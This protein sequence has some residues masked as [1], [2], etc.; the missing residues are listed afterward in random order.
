[1]LLRRLA[2][3]GQ[4]LAPA[5]PLLW[6]VF[7]FWTVLYLCLLASGINEYV[8]RENVTVAGLRQ[9]LALILRFTDAIWIL[10]AACVVH[11]SMARTQGN[12]RARRSALVIVLAAAAAAWASATISLPFGP[13]RYTTA[14]G[15]KIANI[16]PFAVPLLWLV[17]V[18]G[19][20][21]FSARLL[22]G[23]GNAAVALGA[24]CL[25]ALTDLNLEFVAWKLRTW[26][27][28]YPAGHPLAGDPPAW[29]PLQNYLTWFAL[30]TLLSLASP[31]FREG[32][33][34]P[35]RPIIALAI[36]NFLLLTT[37]LLP[38]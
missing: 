4:Y 17:V 12:V 25:T 31:P 9:A 6:G 15:P 35:L 7:L 3:L 24:G 10:L 16:L 22:A 19:A 36:L 8:I 33:K 5:E 2:R 13:L 34:P 14:L 27:I 23:K 30:G 38:N 1:M 18:Q 28:W 29:P 20:R 37:R 21:S 26:W 32:T 11:V